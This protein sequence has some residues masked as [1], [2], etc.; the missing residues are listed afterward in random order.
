MLLWASD[1]HLNFL[2]LQGAVKF[3]GEALMNEN[4]DATGLIITGDISDGKRLER[5][6]R[7][8]AEGFTKPIYFVLGNHDYYNSSWLN[9]DKMVACLV[10]EIP[11]LHWL[12]QG[13]HEVD[14]HVICGV[15]GWYD[16]YHGNAHS[17]VELYDFTNIAELLSESRCRETLLDAVRKRAGHESDQLARMLKAACKTDNVII[18]GTHI[19]PYSESSWHEG[20]LSNR[21]WVPWFSS[22]STGAVLDIFAKRYPEKEFVVLCG[23]SHSPGVYQRM[24]NMTVYTGRAEYGYPELCGMINTKERKMWAYGAAGE[25]VERDY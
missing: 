5:H 23:H 19:A 6:L 12:N 7:A 25:K 8:L 2:R 15:G 17:T 11:H 1:F 9:I 4:P 3:F 14:G 20:K 10:K 13:Y 24:D 18:V 16:A 21:D 22:A